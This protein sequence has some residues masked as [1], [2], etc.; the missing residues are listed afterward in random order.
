LAGK[1]LDA[2]AVSPKGAGGIAQFMPATA[3]WHA[4]ADLE[5]ETCRSTN[6]VLL[7]SNFGRRA[8]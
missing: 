8:K 5:A 1:S 4:L 2:Q 3:S 7:S 6:S